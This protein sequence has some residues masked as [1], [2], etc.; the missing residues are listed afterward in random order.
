[1]LSSEIYSSASISNSRFSSTLSTFK[2]SSSSSLISSDSISDERLK[3]P[4]FS[5]RIR[6]PFVDSFVKHRWFPGDSTKSFVSKIES[7]QA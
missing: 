5:A 2:Y 4:S 3:Q 7:S 1:M 6:P